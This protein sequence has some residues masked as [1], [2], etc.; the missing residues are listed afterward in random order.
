MTEDEA[1]KNGIHTPKNRLKTFLLNGLLL[2][3]VALFMRFVGMAFQ[4]FVTEEAGSEAIGLYSV[5]GG[6]YGFAVT[7]ATSGI[8]LGTTRMISEALGRDDYG[9]VRAARSVC[10]SYAFFFG[11]LATAS[12]HVLTLQKVAPN[13][14]LISLCSVLFLVPGPTAL[15]V[16]HYLLNSLMPPNRFFKNAFLYFSKCSWWKSGLNSLGTVTRTENS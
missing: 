16:F 15:H 10:F 4:L 1:G 5:I 12:S 6:V 7:L 11:L 13:A 8:Q 14:G 3:M 2:T 9:E